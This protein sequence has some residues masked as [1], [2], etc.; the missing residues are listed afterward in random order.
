MVIPSPSTAFGVYR[1]IK[2][3][4]QLRYGDDSLKG[5]RVAGAGRGSRGLPPVQGFGGRGRPPDRNRH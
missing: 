1:G 2:A 5:K 4:A 3:C